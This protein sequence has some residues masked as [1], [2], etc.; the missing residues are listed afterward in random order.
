M[1]QPFQFNPGNE[2]HHKE[3]KNKHVLAT[4]IIS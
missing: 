1:L 2:N 4:E 3:I